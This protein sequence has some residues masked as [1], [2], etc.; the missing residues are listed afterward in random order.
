[1]GSLFHDGSISG[2]AKARAIK[3]QLCIDMNASLMTALG[4]Q[5]KVALVRE[6][7]DEWELVI[8]HELLPELEF[9][10][11]PV[12]RFRKH[13]QMQITRSWC[14]EGNDWERWEE[15]MSP[16]CINNLDMSWLPTKTG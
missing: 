14:E 2:E 13:T 10:E 1:M 5:G 11:H 12:A 8:P 15:G 3:S 6:T 7:E 9:S 4:K 16:E